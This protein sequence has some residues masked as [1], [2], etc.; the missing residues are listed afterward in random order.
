MEFDRIPEEMLDKVSGGLTEE[1]KQYLD[2]YIERC[3]I[4]K[5]PLQTALQV[6]SKN[7][8]SLEEIMYVSEN[9]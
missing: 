6:L 2:T 1:R 8:A 9:W 4:I 5:T 3:K 7:G